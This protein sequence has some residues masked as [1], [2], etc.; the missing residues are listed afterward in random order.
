MVII[1]NSG[2]SG[3]NA[4]PLGSLLGMGL[5]KIEGRAS[6]NVENRRGKKRKNYNRSVY[7]S[8]ALVSQFGI[9][10]LV[11]IFLLSFLGIQIDKYFHTSYWIVLLF[12]VGAAAGFRNIFVM[13][14]K[15]YDKQEGRR[16]GRAT[17]KEDRQGT[18]DRR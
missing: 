8:L 12:F 10:M 17:A 11:P 14:K 9:N 16:T 3:K 1:L 5:Y 2:N 6:N 7:Q 13:A 18:D 4:L 15:I